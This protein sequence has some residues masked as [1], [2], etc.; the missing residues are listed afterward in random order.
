MPRKMKEWVPSGPFGEP[1][2]GESLPQMLPLLSQAS[3]DPKPQ[4]S[5]SRR[6]ERSCEHSIVLRASVRSEGGQQQAG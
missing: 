3:R 1:E 4:D 2:S 6:K 5:D